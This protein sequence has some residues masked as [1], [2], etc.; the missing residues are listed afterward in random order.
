MA[1]KRR[2][3]KKSNPIRRT[4]RRNIGLH[5]DDVLGK[6][7]RFDDG[8]FGGGRRRQNIS[9]LKSLTNIV[10]RVNHVKNVDRYFGKMTTTVLRDAV[11]ER[12]K[13]V[14]TRR[15]EK[16]RAL[17]RIGRAGKGVAGPVVKILTAA[18]KVRCK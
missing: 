14:C 18:S 13:K 9:L 6:S 10:G 17:F 1:K 5:R 12:K 7:R 11:A 2:S 16:R 3:L 4:Q 8:R 15:A